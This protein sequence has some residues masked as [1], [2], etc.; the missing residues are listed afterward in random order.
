MAAASQWARN[1]LEERQKAGKDHDY[2]IT[3]ADEEEYSLDRV[4]DVQ[5]PLFWGHWRGHG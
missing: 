4:G 1:V 5:H 3:L 2:E